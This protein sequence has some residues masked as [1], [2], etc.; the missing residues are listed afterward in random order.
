MKKTIVNLLI[1]SSVAAFVIGC[2][3]PCQSIAPMDDPIYIGGYTKPI[4]FNYL[5]DDNVSMR[6]ARVKSLEL[7]AS[8]NPSAV[9]IV[10]YADKAGKGYANN[11]AKNIQIDAMKNN[12]QILKTKVIGYQNT[13]PFE[14]SLYLN[15]KPLDK[16][17]MA[18]ESS[19]KITPK[20][21]S[22]TVLKV[23]DDES[24]VSVMDNLK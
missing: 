10:R 4:V 8:Q 15:F 20:T 16:S 21:N 5:I 19:G 2:A 7:V 12:G 3:T 9:L 1:S 14:V 17:V 6:D 11:L 24:M 13:N 22:S 23:R 18:I